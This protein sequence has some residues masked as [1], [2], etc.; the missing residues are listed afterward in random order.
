M[1]LNPVF[2]AIPEHLGYPVEQDQYQGNERIYAVYCYTDERGSVFGNN[3]PLID[4]VYMRLQLYTPQDFNYMELKHR[5]RDYLEGQ[6]FRMTS[7]R[8]WLEPDLGDG[9]GKIRCT[10]MSMEYA[11]EH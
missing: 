10:A 2:E 5:T 1:N 9:A 11:G 6:G 3:I 8:T 7:I 4:T